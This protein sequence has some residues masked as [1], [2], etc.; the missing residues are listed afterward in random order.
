MKKILSLMFLV[1]LMGFL[2]VGDAVAASNADSPTVNR[3]SGT[4]LKDG[5]KAMTDG[6]RKKV[7]TVEMMLRAARK[8]KDIERLDDINEKLIAMKGLLN[9]AEGYYFD[10][11]ENLKAGDIDAARGKY[12]MIQISA[13]KLQEL[14]LQV[15]A[16]SEPG[17]GGSSGQP[18]VVEWEQTVE[19][20][21]EG[22]PDEQID[23]TVYLDPPPAPSPYM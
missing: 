4:D 13:G 9:L 23:T 16:G 8:A 12:R 6:M 17:S 5:G 18:S 10:L 1:P 7:E 15:A 22:E 2:W 3:M 14:N 19:D 11:V 21:P 20:L